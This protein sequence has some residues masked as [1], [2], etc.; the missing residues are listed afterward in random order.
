MFNVTLAAKT[1]LLKKLAGKNAAADLALRM[2]R[3]EGG[4]SL[5]LD[6]ALPSDVTIAHRGRSVL[7]MDE[8][9]SQALSDKMLDAESTKA[10]AR[11][12][13]K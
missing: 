3:R 12:K 5:R 4:W 8:A 10:G 7:L 1:R 6:R 11:L 13:L 9:V 2:T